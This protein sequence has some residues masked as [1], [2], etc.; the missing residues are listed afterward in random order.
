MEK[1]KQ[2]IIKQLPEEF[3]HLT[4]CIQAL[5]IDA[6][7]RTPQVQAASS[8]ATIVGRVGLL[9]SGLIIFFAARGIAGGVKR[10]WTGVVDGD[11]RSLWQF[12]LCSF[13]ALLFGI[14]L[15][16]PSMLLNDHLKGYS[17]IRT[18]HIKGGVVIATLMVIAIVSFLLW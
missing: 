13:G 6:L 9:V 18:L 8:V 16:M 14:L 1:W 12:P 2:T 10:Q 11:F 7:K 4:P 15:L 17:H 5:D 3:Q